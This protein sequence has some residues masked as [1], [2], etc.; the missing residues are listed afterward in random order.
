MDP[1]T[2]PRSEVPLLTLPSPCH[3]LPCAAI[4]A[5][6]MGLGKTAQLITYLGITRD[7]E[8]D[9]GPN[10][11]V[12]PASL[13]EN[14]QR[15]LRRWCP[16]PRVVVYYGKHRAAV[17]RRLDGLRQRLAAG[18]PV[19]DDLSDLTDPTLLAELA[20]SDKLADAEAAGDLEDDDD[21]PLGAAVL[22][23]S[24]DEFDVQREKDGGAAAAEEPAPQWAMDAESVAAPFDVML[25][26][27]TLF[28]RDSPEQ[29]LD[30]S[31]LEKWRWSHLVMD[32]A[33]ALKNRAA[34]R[35][36]RLRRVANASKRRIMMTG[37][38]LQNDLAELQSLLHFLLPAVFAEQGFEDLAGMLQVRG[39]AGGGFAGLVLL[40]RLASR[41][42]SRSLWAAAV[43]PPAMADRW[44]SA[45]SRPPTT[46]RATRPRLRG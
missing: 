29:R 6:E 12:V 20:A 1:G 45:P 2:P 30:R 44:S 46:T 34:S 10:L 19:D 40:S 5:D 23:E 28:E 3:P 16:S 43:A 35:T 24:D 31:F 37:T 8:G 17:R 11:V 15:E 9:R 36:T 13:L 39:R 26:C 7:V 25:T 42:G 33:H 38:P 32:E 21:D 27:Y 41:L 18:E 4:L 22:H 14:W